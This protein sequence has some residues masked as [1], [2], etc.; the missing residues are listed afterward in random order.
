LTGVLE[1]ENLS[2]DRDGHVKTEAEMGCAATNQGTLGATEAG[3][4]KNSFPRC[5]RKAQTNQYLDF[6]LLVSNAM[7]K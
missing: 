1:D 6:G 5:F 2:T 4:D 3:R 7:R